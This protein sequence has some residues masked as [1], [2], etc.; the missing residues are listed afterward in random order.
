MKTKSD[1]VDVNELLVCAREL[2]LLYNRKRSQCAQ[3]G[4]ITVPNCISKAT[5]KQ[6]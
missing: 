5:D 3:D 2:R 4:H 1:V 6:T